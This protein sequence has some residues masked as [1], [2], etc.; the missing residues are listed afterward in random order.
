MPLHPHHHHH[1][2]HP[3]PSIII[4]NTVII[5]AV[6]AIAM[7]IVIG[8][9][10]PSS[11]ASAFCSMQELS[12]TNLPPVHYR[13][14]AASTAGSVT[15]AST[16]MQGFQTKHAGKIDLEKHSDHS[17]R[18]CVISSPCLRLGCGLLCLLA[19]MGSLPSRT[20]SWR[21]CSLPPCCDRETS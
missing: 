4:N 15:T 8:Q 20:E 21:R 13:F 3:G 11:V 10:H 18:P 1:H 16:C 14:R 19:T 12:H 17:E 9:Y 2:H 5:I 6:I 7:T